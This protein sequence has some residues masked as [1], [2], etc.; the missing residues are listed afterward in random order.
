MFGPREDGQLV[1]NKML[2]APKRSVRLRAQAWTCPRGWCPGLWTTSAASHSALNV[3]QSICFCVFYWRTISPFGEPNSILCTCFFIYSQKEKKKLHFNCS[4][5]A[6]ISL[7]LPCLCLCG[8]V[9]LWEWRIYLCF[10]Q[11]FSGSPSEALWTT[12]GWET[13][14]EDPERQPHVNPVSSLWSP[15]GFHSSQK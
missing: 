10:L 15:W 9:H 4:L 6:L 3:G 2:K 7:H 11:L 8:N 13:G 12:M 14:M 5:S 1:K